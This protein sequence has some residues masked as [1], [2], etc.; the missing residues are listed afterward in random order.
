VYPE[1]RGVRLEDM[2]TLFGDASVMPTPA[3]GAGGSERQ[4]L[5]SRVG[6]PVPSLDIRR[7]GGPSDSPYIA[8]SVSQA[9]VDPPAVTIEN[10]K[11]QLP[12]RHDENGEGVGGWI[13]RMVK[14]GKGDDKDDGAGEY[15]RL[16]RGDEEEE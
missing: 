5:M 1:T 6:S 4:S 13:T 11:P 14:R 8:G 10:G 16:E 15:S 12:E 2:D 3:F 9:D 7:N